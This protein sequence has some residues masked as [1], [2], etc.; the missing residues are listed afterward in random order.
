VNKFLLFTGILVLNI[1]ILAGEPVPSQKV[2]FLKRH[3]NNF[4]QDLN[5]F[6]Q[7]FVTS[8]SSCADAERQEAGRAGGRVVAKGLALLVVL[9]G[10]GYVAKKGAQK[11][12]LIGA[13]AIAGASYAKIRKDDT[14]RKQQSHAMD[15]E[16]KE[17]KKKQEKKA[18]AE[19][20]KRQAG[21][22][23]GGVT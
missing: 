15:Q 13:K 19:A 1:S 20:R 10:G 7:C 12:V 2:P 18:M 14:L 8:S 5:A 4:K 21:H 3:Y 16:D 9:V 11:I 6:K 22:Q 17:H 23:A